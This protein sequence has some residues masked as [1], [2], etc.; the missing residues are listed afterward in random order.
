[1]PRISSTTGTWISAPVSL[2][3]ISLVVELAAGDMTAAGIEVYYGGGVRPIP[4]DPI[5]FGPSRTGDVPA[6]TSSDQL[7]FC[8]VKS[9]E[10]YPVTWPVIRCWLFIDPSKTWP[11]VEVIISA[12]L[13][14]T[15]PVSATLPRELSTPAGDHQDR[16]RLGHAGL[17]ASRSPG[18]AG[19]VIDDSNT[20]VCAVV[21]EPHVLGRSLARGAGRSDQWRGCLRRTSGEPEEQH[22]GQG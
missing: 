15:Y 18:V 12:P 4:I 13:G 20:D 16:R 2:R 7:C 21:I 3:K 17:R 1:M 8:Q 22:W 10:Q 14:V 9:Y 5:S 19:A 11:N 6:I